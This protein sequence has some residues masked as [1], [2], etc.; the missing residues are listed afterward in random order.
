MP[1]HSRDPA[2]I[3]VFLCDQLRIDLLGC[4]GGTQVRTPNIDALAAQSMVFDQAYT[5]CALCSP[6]RAS[7]MT[8]VYPHRHHMFNN[9][10]PGYS[11]CEHLRSDLQTLPGWA[12]AHSRHETAYFGKWHIGPAQDL[13]DSPFHHTHPKPGEA[14]LLFLASS[15]WHPNTSVGK[16]V[17]SYG[18][19]AAGTIDV[20]IDRF[21]DGA[22]AGFTKRFLR[23]RQ[24]DSPPFLAFCAFPGPHSPW[25]VPEEFGVRYDPAAIP[26][27]PNRYDTFAGKPLNQKKLRALQMQQG[28]QSFIKGGDDALRGRLACCFSYLE[29][30]DML[31]GEVLSELKEA[32]QYEDT[33]VVFTADHGDMAGAHG[34]TSKGAYMYDEIYRIPMIIKPAGPTGAAR[35]TAAPVHLMDLTATIMDLV[36]GEPVQ[37]MDTH[38]LHGESLLP[39]LSGTPPW[40]RAVHYAEY[41]GDWYGHYSSR[42]VTDGRWKLVWNLSDF[43]ELYDLE[44]DPHELTN[45]FYEPAQRPTRE[46]YFS[47]LMAEAARYEDKHVA[48][49]DPAVEERSDLRFEA[50]L[51]GIPPIAQERRPQ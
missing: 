39:F 22:A 4:Y 30:I 11:Y 8:G 41:H 38:P 37:A 1:N 17:Q 18:D 10:T 19:G 14:D 2:N 49:L 15:H 23:Q 27:W 47:L 25:L 12:D 31:V 36:A 9:S 50:S 48:L 13:F 45:R 34:F 51:A 29:L 32:G 3:L 26:M 6:A 35:R 43:C 46:H 24:P 28:H 40:E 16:M 5:P 33:T 7:L 20:P 44:H 42:M 21:P